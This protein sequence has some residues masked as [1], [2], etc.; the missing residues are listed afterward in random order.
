M[1]AVHRAAFGLD[2]LLSFPLSVDV[3]HSTKTVSR[4]RFS[5]LTPLFSLF[6]SFALSIFTP[7]F[8]TL[9]FDLAFSLSLVSVPTFPSL[10]LLWCPC[11]YCLCAYIMPP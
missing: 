9:L 1:R 10:L 4:Y 7:Y 3:R 6:Y 11:L 8:T 2:L 5:Y